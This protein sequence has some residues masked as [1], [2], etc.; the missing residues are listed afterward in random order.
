MIIVTS[1]GVIRK[2]IKDRNLRKNMK[3]IPKKWRQ[4][5]IQER[6]SIPET[7]FNI[8]SKKIEIIRSIQ[9]PKKKLI[10]SAKLQYDLFEEIHSYLT[11]WIAGYGSDITIRNYFGS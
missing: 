1:L 3:E 8:S 9:D 7:Y 4:L 10:A 5:P 6:L 2:V 11:A